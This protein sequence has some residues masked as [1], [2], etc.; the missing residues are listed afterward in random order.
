MLLSVFISQVAFISLCFS[1]A[2]AHECSVLVR[3]F[4]LLSVLCVYVRESERQKDQ[5]K[6]IYILPCRYRA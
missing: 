5:S 2:H 1:H 6:E 3:Y 4:R